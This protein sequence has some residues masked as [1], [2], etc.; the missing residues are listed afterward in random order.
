MRE[1]GVLHLK[2]G[3]IELVLGADPRVPQEKLTVEEN[4]TT[5]LGIG[6][7]HPSL[8]LKDLVE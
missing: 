8:G 2:A 1:G 5:G 4:P 6:Y 3:N 7:D